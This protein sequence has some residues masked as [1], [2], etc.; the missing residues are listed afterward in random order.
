LGGD[1]TQLSWLAIVPA[2]LVVFIIISQFFGSQ[3]LG[4]VWLLAWPGEPRSSN[5]WILVVVGGFGGIS[6]LLVRH[7]TAAGISVLGKAVSLLGGVLIYSN[8][9]CR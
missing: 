8:L 2:G 6:L 5:N 3:D 7:R 1:Q 4:M 9:V